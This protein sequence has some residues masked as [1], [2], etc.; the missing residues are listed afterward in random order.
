MSIIQTVTFNLLDNSLALADFRIV[1]QV[2]CTFQ[3]KE[4]LKVVSSQLN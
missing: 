1:Q 4:A 2:Y 3:R